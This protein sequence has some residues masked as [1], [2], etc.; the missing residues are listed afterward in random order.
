[1]VN[2]LQGEGIAPA[3]A[4]GSAAADA[5]LTDP[6]RAAQ[7]YRAWVAATH[8]SYLSVAAPVHVASISGSPRRV[9]WLC[10]ALTAPGLSR[11]LAG[12]WA[13]SWNDLRDGAPPGLHA[14]LAAS[15][16]G[17]ARAAT[18]RSATRRRL[19]RDLAEATAPT[20]LEEDVAPCGESGRQ[21][22]LPAARERPPDA[23]GAR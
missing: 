1:M 17:I 19:A 12:P 18:S 4:S 9:W 16:H 2:P 7:S 10:R 20:N 3:M 22:S 5:V 14:A 8:Q 23:L 15:A 11:I 6:V 21:E 13:L